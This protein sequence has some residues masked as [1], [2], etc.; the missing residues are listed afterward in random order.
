MFPL[1]VR[2]KVCVASFHVRSKVCKFAP[3]MD[4]R[5]AD[6]APHME[7]SHAHFAPQME[8][9]H[10]FRNQIVAKTACFAN[11][12]RELVKTTNILGVYMTYV[13]T[14]E[15]KK[16][17]WRES[18]FKEVSQVPQKDNFSFCDTTL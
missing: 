16:N 17:I 13:T 18:T 6:F 5:N 14:F 7:G 11:V 1:Y 4:G 2:S 12:Q 8:R 3:Q 15:N 10:S 9:R